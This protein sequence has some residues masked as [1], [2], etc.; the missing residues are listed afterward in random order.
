MRAP[1]IRS[2]L[3]YLVVACIVPASLM[4]ILLIAYDYTQARTAFIIGAMATARANATDVDKEFATV[5]AALR[6][7]ATS[8]DLAR[9]DLAAFYGQAR[10]LAAAQNMLN[11]VLE[12]AGGQQLL[13][14]F[15]PYGA[16]LP[17][18]KVGPALRHIQQ[19]EATAISNLFVGAVS[20]RHVASIG[21]P[22]RYPADRPDTVGALSA[23]VTVERFNALLA[24]Q[25]YP[26][27]WITSILDREGIVVAR[28]QD[29][30]R[31][32]G[33]QALPEVMKRMHEGF[34]GAIET[35]TLDGKPILAVMT[36]A[37]ASGWTVGIGIPLEVLNA[38]LNRKLWLLVLVTVVMLGASLLTA[39][40][41][42]NRITQSIGA[43]VAPAMALGRGEPV[44]AA[45]YGLREANE[46]G[47]ALVDAA[48]MHA[49]ARHQAT[50]DP[51]TG[52]ANR[53]MFSQFLERQ[54]E[55]CARSGT[56]LS[57]LYLDLDRFKHINDT[58][59]HNAGDLL[60]TGAAARLAAELRKSD[61]AARL[62]GDEFAVVLVGSDAADTALVVAKL[63]TSL[64][65]PHRIEGHEL[66][67]GASIGVAM[68]A[69]PGSAPR[70]PVTAAELVADADDAMYQRKAERKLAA[71]DQSLP[72]A[73]M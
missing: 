59:G 15:V 52:L 47:N 24:Q 39:W 49:L 41:I 50:H 51:L 20:Q 67:A 6:A 28:S 60:L 5:E 45:R 43:L 4:A 12:N 37:G 38:E 29:M 22:V 57:L 19:H 64:G 58:Y 16:A 40:R 66:V 23:S 35:S 1:S 17:P 9:N 44:V 26:Q 18:S 61:L 73:S 31:F 63:E 3:L 7:L 10:G 62:G 65:L 32:V 36:R 68:L 14:T 11:I 54:L 46:V 13:N 30:Q 27:H 8:P 21:I 72:A 70:K 69:A 25:S 42:G 33:H 53:A 55:L 2:R 56:P 34:E 71:R 48:R